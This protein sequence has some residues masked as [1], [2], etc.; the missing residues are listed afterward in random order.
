MSERETTPR[1]TDLTEHGRQCDAGPVWLLTMVSPLQRPGAVYQRAMAGGLGGQFDDCLGRNGADRFR[2]LGVFGLTVFAAQQ[3][4]RESVEALAIAGDKLC[5]MQAARKQRMRHAQ[6]QRGVGVRPDRHPPGL[7][8]V[9]Y[10]R[11]SRADDDET[12][13]RIFCALDPLVRAM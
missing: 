7:Q 12:H 10:I 11:S 9:G 1:K 3:I 4:G 13:T 8:A 6:H 5:V 2:P